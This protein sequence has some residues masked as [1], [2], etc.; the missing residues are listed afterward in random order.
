M[1]IQVKMPTWLAQDD[2]GNWHFYEVRPTLQYGIMGLTSP[3]WAMHPTLKRF[4]T[5]VTGFEGD[6]KDSLHRW[7]GVE[8]EQVK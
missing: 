4:P 8:W 7:N 2:L 3:W 5:K 1:S 6:W